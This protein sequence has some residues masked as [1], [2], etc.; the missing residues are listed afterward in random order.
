MAKGVKKK[1]DISNRTVLVMLVAVIVVAAI[2]LVLYIN[3]VNDA[4]PV[5]GASDQAELGITIVEAPG[6]T[7]GP[8]PVHASAELGLR[9]EEPPAGE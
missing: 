6:S 1:D 7:E 3:A 4:Q 2:S 5:V 9:I 8:E